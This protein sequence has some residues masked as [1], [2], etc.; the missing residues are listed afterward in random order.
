MVVEL[1]FFYYYYYYYYYHYYYY[2]Y[3]IGPHFLQRVAI[4]F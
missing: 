2:Y 4:L 1:N 3:W